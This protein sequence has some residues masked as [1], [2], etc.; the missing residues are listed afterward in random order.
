MGK[1]VDLERRAH[2]ARA[3]PI[4]ARGLERTQERAGNARQMVLDRLQLAAAGRERAGEQG[5]REHR[6]PAVRAAVAAVRRVAAVGPKLL[7]RV[8]ST[9]P[10]ARG[11]SLPLTRPPSA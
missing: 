8:R 3:L 4:R 6:T 2:Q 5:A 7:N 1:A 11:A 9:A 10:K